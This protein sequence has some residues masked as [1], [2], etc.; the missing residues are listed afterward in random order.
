MARVP[1]QLITVRNRRALR[2]TDLAEL[3][4]LLQERV[5]TVPVTASGKEVISWATGGRTHPDAITTDN[6]S[7]AAYVPYDESF[8]GTRDRM[9]IAMQLTGLYIKNTT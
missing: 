8:E 2:K 5:E 4:S 6:Q 7:G 3:E 9:T 1:G